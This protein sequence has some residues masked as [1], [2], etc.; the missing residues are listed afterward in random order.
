MTSM[1]E[2]AK[3]LVGR[4]SLAGRVDA[5]AQ[6][7]EAAR[8]RLSEEA[9]AE[10]EGV[11]ARTGDRLRLTSQHTV[12]AIAGATGSG[13]SSTFNALTGLDL[14]AVGMLRKLHAALSA[15]GIRLAVV[16]P[17]GGV[18]DLL[19]REGFAELVGG[20]DRAVTLV[21]ILAEAERG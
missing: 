3:R 4:G 10:A 15:Q 2:G 7:A 16:G 13:K 8:G 6:A 5:L 1:I 19:R 20:I 17:H 21:S 12:V 18:R 9:V 11:V 14:A